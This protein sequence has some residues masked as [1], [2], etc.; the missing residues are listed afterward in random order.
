MKTNMAKKRGKSRRGD[1]LFAG[2]LLFYPL[3]H[4]LVFTVYANL[5]SLRLAFMTVNKYGEY[6]F[7]GFSNFGRIFTEWSALG[8]KSPLAEA[9]FN[10]FLWLPV[11][12]LLLIPI[13]LV[14]TYFLF[15]KVPGEKFFRIVFFLPSIISVVALTLLFR[16]M[17]NSGFGPVNHILRGIGLGGIIPQAGWLGQ[18]ST[19]RPLVFFYC[20]W[21]GIGYNIVLMQGALSQ[22]P[23]EIFES[24]ELDGISMTRELW[25][26]VVPLIFP[27]LSTLILT[28]A[29]AMFTICLQPMLITGTGE[30]SV[31]TVAGLI[32]SNTKSG[33]DNLLIDAAVYGVLTTLIG[34]P[35]IL[36]IKFALEK[37]TP[38]VE[39]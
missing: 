22:V 4:L 9:A 30:N 16:F 18:T 2:A 7:A 33:V 8:S 6:S 25:Q 35:V 12:L 15:K 10:S 28:S 19:S 38:D 37:A 5:S 21:A 1:V 23:K 24:A 39:Y 27:T 17:F 3:L 29:T 32:L 20:I 31:R 26:I 13:S 34:A 11:N 36:S 14:C